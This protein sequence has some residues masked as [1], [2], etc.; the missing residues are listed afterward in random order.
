M[1]AEVDGATYHSN[2]LVKKV[3]FMGTLYI[4]LNVK[5]QTSELIKIHRVYS[6]VQYLQV[7]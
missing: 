2:F 1:K 6:P 5:S 3:Y 4:S 7:L